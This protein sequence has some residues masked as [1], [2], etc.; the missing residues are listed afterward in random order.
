MRDRPIGRL[1]LHDQGLV[2]ADR[3]PS[4]EPLGAA[5][6]GAVR[7]A[8]ARRSA[9]TPSDPWAR[10]RATARRR[11]SCARAPRGALDRGAARASSSRRAVPGRP[12][13]R[14]QGHGLDPAGVRA[15]LRRPRPRGARGRRARRHR[16]ARRRHLDEPRRLDQQGR[17]LVGR[18]PHRL[19]RRRHRHAR[20]LARDRPRPPHRAR[21]RRGQPRRPARRAGRDV[22]ARRPAAAAGRHD[23]RP[24]RRAR[25]R[26]VVVRHLRG[27]PVDPRRHAERRHARARRAARTSRS[28]RRRSGSSSPAARPGSPRSAQDLEWTFLH[29]LSRL[30]RPD[31]EAGVLPPLHAPDRPGAAER[32]ARARC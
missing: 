23:L 11:P 14:A 19:V 10:V 30:G 29:A 16:L 13:P 6:R 1:R 2:A 4:R 27:R 25:A 22:V 15:L 9:P 12:R 17:D 3:G 7:R 5:Q 8:G 24:V 26:A 32:H 20:A 28:S 31:G 21:D 18:R